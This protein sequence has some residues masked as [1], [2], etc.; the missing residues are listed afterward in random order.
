[1]KTVHLMHYKKKTFRFRNHILTA[2]QRNNYE[3]RSLK[4]YQQVEIVLPVLILGISMSLLYH[5]I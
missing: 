5:I 4:T 2:E 1:M 3:P